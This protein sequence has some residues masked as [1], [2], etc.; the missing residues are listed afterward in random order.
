M[1]ARI[2]IAGG[3]SKDYADPTP[4][5][6]EPMLFLDEGAPSYPEVDETRPDPYDVEVHHDQHRQAVAAWRDAI[7]SFFRTSVFIQTPDGPHEV[8][9]KYLG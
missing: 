6:F 5:H 3:E 1:R 7:R 2:H 8:S 4:L 9:V